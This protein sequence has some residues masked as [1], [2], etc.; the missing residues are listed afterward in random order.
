MRMD[1]Y[2]LYTIVFWH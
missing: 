1:D 2:R